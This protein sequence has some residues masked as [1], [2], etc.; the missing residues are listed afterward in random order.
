MSTTPFKK[1]ALVGGG[2]A[3]GKPVL[4][5][6]LATGTTEVTVL[7]RPDSTTSFPA[8]PNLEVERADPT[9]INAV[10]VVLKKLGIE[11][12]IS[13]VGSAGTASQHAL[14][15]AAKQAGVRLFVPSE[16]G[17]PTEGVTNVHHLAKANVP[18]YA[19]SIGL[20]TLRVYNGLFAEFI[21][22]LGSVQRGTFLV[23][24]PLEGH[25]PPLPFSITSLADVGGF[26]AHVLTTLP[27]AELQDT[28]L[29]IEGKRMTLPDLAYLYS[30]IKSVPVEHVSDIP[31]DVGPDGLRVWRKHLL[32]EMNSGRSRATWDPVQGRDLGLGAL[33]N[34]LWEGHK[35]KTAEE[36]I[37]GGQ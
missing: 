37:R 14:I 7:T 22:M 4:E 26:L 5:A 10:S 20:P 21:P 19:K 12:L 17:L 30:R 13:A 36:A 18:I 11:V 3:V 29:R 25:G 8:H 9:D 6:L 1:I 31:P 28:T 27:P 32:E 2:G 33:S 15:D 24:D 16:F 23:L 35:W 34:G